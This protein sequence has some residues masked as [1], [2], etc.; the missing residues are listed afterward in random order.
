MKQDNRADVAAVMLLAKYDKLRRE[1]REIEQPL[2]KAVTAY[3]VR[4]GIWGFSIDHLRRAVEEAEKEPE[5][6]AR[7]KYDGAVRL[8]KQIKGE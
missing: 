8:L 1:L 7:E 2:R 3:G 5:P 6:T 4:R